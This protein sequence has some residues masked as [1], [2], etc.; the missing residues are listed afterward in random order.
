MT[1]SALTDQIRESTTQRTPRKAKIDTFLIHHQAGTNDDAVIAGMPAHSGVSANYTI[2]NEGR[3]TLVVNEDFRAW[4]SGS[5][6]DGGKGAAWDHRSITVEIENE[7]GAPDWPISQA[8]IDKA[9]R[10]LNDLRGRYGISFVLGHRDLYDP[11][12]LAAGDPVE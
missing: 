7:A 6:S 10:L 11:I 4:T 8:A 3:L 12:D 9:A 1:H 2:A 5:T